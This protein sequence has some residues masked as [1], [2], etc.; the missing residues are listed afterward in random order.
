MPMIRKAKTTP[1]P[2]TVDEFYRLVPDGQKADLIDGVVCMA[3]PDT[4]KADDLTN[5]IHV[6]MDIYTA[7]REL[8]GKVRGSRFAF[9]LTRYRAP[10]PDV[11]YIR[12]E[13]LRLTTRRWMKGGP[14]VA[15][16]VVSRGSRKRDYVTKKEL[17]E[18]AGVSEY[19]IIDP[20]KSRAEF[21]RLEKGKYQ[22]VSLENDHIFRS[23]VLPGFWLDV[24][25]LF[26]KELPNSYE[27]LQQILA[28]SPTSR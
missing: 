24:N 3:S 27:C 20:L 1:E 25:W 10:E 26:G 11:S 4:P 15:I 8:G 17:Y 28:S 18:A 14:D 6:L 5:F 16:E 7:A 22:P 2:V 21:H 9:R 13:R 12:K 19:W 23:A